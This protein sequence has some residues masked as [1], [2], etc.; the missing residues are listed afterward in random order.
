M[1]N[2]KNVR[3]GKRSIII[4]VMLVSL[5]FVSSATAVPQTHGSIVVERLDKIEKV[6]TISSILSE[7]IDTK[8]IDSDKVTKD[9]VFMLS[10]ITDQIISMARSIDDDL[11][12][13]SILDAA[14]KIKLEEI[15]EN[16]VILKTQECLILISNLIDEILTEKELSK[17]EII[18]FKNLK[19]YTLKTLSSIDDEVLNSD[20]YTQQEKEKL[21]QKL[22]FII[23]LILLIPF[24]ILKG[25]INGLIGITIGVLRSI[26]A[27]IKLVILSFTGAQGI[28]TLTAFF[29]IFIGV[30]S[31]IGIKFFS[32][33]AS[34]VL[35]IITARLVPAIGSL[36]GGLSLAIHSALALLIIFAI[37]IAI[38][39]IIIV[40]ATLLGGGN[41]TAILASVLK[42]IFGIL[43]LI[44]GLEDILHQMW[45]W[46]EEN[47]QNWPEWPFETQTTIMH[48]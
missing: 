22:L 1:Q 3:L 29:I 11:D 21:I 27:L 42:T 16:E 35:A 19:T 14:K 25:S 36:L 37:P 4:G 39:I 46:L 9:S 45:N 31:K 17:E 38:A 40:L 20:I 18:L 30:M 48:L 12:T 6:K 23:L 7:T 15:N 43:I 10:V 32:N 13:F 41:I 34:P 2:K 26:C 44:P 28:L 47:I 24:M 5:L 8:N 33:I